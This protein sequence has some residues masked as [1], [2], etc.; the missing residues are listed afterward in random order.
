MICAPGFVLRQ[1]GRSLES[2]GFRHALVRRAK[3]VL[4][5]AVI[6]FLLDMRLVVVAQVAMLGVGMAMHTQQQLVRHHGARKQQEQKEGDICREAMH[7]TVSQS[8]Q[9]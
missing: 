9:R 5:R 7:L 4:N 3:Q 2:E 6:V 8:K 1:K